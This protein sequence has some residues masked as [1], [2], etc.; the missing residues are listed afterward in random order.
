MKDFRSA[1]VRSPVTNNKLQC[2][3]GNMWEKINRR[4]YWLLLKEHCVT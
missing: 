3:L 4:F 1:Y 2:T